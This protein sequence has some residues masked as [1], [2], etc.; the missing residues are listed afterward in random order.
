MPWFRVEGHFVHAG[1]RKSHRAGFFIHV[2]EGRDAADALA[3]Y[4]KLE[5]RLGLKAVEHERPAVRHNLGVS[6]FPT[7][8][9]LSEPQVRELE[10][11]IMKEGEKSMREELGR[12]LR[13]LP[14]ARVIALIQEARASHLTEA[15][16]SHYIPPESL[17]LI[18]L[19]GRREE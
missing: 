12:K 3:K 1:I 6:F 19:L 8:T 5:S 17:K 10:Q 18:G 13:S 14:Q 16:R 7:I 15:R 11:L 9:P 2:P 4:R